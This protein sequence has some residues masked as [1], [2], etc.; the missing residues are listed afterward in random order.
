M[1]AFRIMQNPKIKNIIIG[2]LCFAFIFA[3]V[4]IY[5]NLH[6]HIMNDGYLIVHGHASAK[7]S[8]S[9]SPV[10]FHFH[11]FFELLIL[12]IVLTILGIV[13]LLLVIMDLKISRVIPYDALDF[14]PHSN[15]LII[16]PIF[17]A[18]PLI[19]H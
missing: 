19:S 14:I 10:K 12:N 6:F 17:R 13:L 8:Q 15:P 11:S 2:I 16:L 4:I 7:N 9:Q 3:G 18:P 5:S 1:V